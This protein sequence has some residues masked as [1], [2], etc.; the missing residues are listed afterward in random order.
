ME[1][2]EKFWRKN[3]SQ[4]IAEMHPEIKTNIKN[5]IDFKKS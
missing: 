4:R 3:E 5:T 2:S 1:S